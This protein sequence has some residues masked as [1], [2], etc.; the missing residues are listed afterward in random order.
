MEFLRPHQ[1][2]NQVERWKLERHPLDVYDAVIERYAVEGPDAIH[3]VE[4]EMERLKWVGIYPQ[5]QGGDAFMLRIKIPGGRLTSAQAATI[6]VIADEFARGPEPN[7]VWGDGFLDLTTRQDIQMHW[8]KMGAIPEIWRRL[9]AVGITTVQACGDSA[10]NV[11]CCPVAG[12]D[13][14]EVLDAYPVAA[15]ISDYFTGNR[16]YANLPRKFK[17][18]VTGC[19]EDCAKA[20]INDISLVPA[21]A[22]DGA[23]GFNVLVG[24]GLSDGPRIASDVDIFVTSEQA[25]EI[26]RAI[27]QLFGE[28]GNRENRWTSRLRYLVQELGPEGFR[29]EI[30]K[31]AAFELAPAGEHLGKRHRGDHIGVHPQVRDGLCYV[32][33]NVTVGRMSGT[34][35]SELAQLAGEYGD[36]ELR[37]AT[38]QNLVLTGVPE[39]RLPE[40]LSEPLLETYSPQPKPFERGVVACTGNEFCR[41]AIVETKARALEWARHMDAHITPNG[42]PVV[43]MHFSGCSASCAQP[44]IADIG[45]RGE[46][47]KTDDAIVEA[48]DI[49]LGGSLGRDAA[50]I[51]WV[52]G[53]V[54]VAQTPN[55]LVHLYRRYEREHLAG[56]QFHEWARRSPNSELRA[57]LAQGAE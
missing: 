26:M 52:A 56:E 19:T 24:G 14:E 55:A 44:Q 57:A 3:S 40:L 37:L 35:L 29:A 38:D 12:I 28:L 25:V 7:P 10:R 21:R 30:A 39:A 33:L 1:Q 23:L 6:G 43:R 22:H 11:L 54:P 45:F 2:L 9:E 5:R 13:R 49:G 4:G 34:H 53:S 48:V 47:A 51:D 16:E 41:F 27:A 8:L 15:A 46:T 42:N 31:R 32:G 17:L 20:E 18:S 50:F 36:G